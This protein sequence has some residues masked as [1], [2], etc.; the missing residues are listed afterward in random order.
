VW[1][2]F[3]DGIIYPDGTT[4]PPPAVAIEK[5]FDCPFNEDEVKTFEDGVIL[6]Y[7]I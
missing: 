6:T 1:R 2:F 5:S 3:G 4:N 7:I